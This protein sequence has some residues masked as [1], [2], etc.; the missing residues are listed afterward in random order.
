MKSDL[1]L[2]DSF[3]HVYNRGISKQ[4][5]FYDDADYARFLF[6]LL[7]LQ[8]P[9]S[10][11]QSRRYVHKYLSKKDFS[12]PQNI[13]EKIQEER[14]VKILNFCIM[15]NHFHITIQSV[16]DDGISR[17][18]QKLGNAYA[19]YFNKRY[20]K[21]GHVFESGYKV[22]LILTDQQLVYL[23]AYIHRNPNEINTWKDKSFEYPWSSYQD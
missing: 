18:M 20:E 21:T 7:H 16:S 5:L 13:I 22:K 6:L 17:Y 12:V 1:L 2:K 19:K 3:Y 8:S 4:T 10:F 11:D 15:P 14:F 23:S 9:V